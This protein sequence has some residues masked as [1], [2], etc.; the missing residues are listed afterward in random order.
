MDFAREKASVVQRAL[1]GALKKGHHEINDYDEDDEGVAGGRGGGGGNGGQDDNGVRDHDISTGTVEYK[2]Y[3]RRFIGLGALILLNIVGSW[4]WLTFAALSDTT[5]QYFRTSEAEVNWMSTAF[6]FSFA[7]ATPGVIWCMERFGPKP[8]IVTSAVLLI[9]GNWVRYAGT[10]TRIF[11]VAMFGQIVIGI[12]QPFFLSIPTKYSDMWFS[13]KGRTSATAIVSLSNPLGGALGS[14]IDP[15]LAGEPHQVP[16]MVLY[17]SII[18][19]A[20]AAPCFFIPARPP[21]PPNAVVAGEKAPYWSSLKRL[22]KSPEFLVIWLAFSIYVGLFNA[23]SSLLN[24]ILSPHGFTEDEAGITGALLIFVGL[25]AAAIISP[26][27]DYYKHY[28]TTVKILVPLIAATYVGLIWAPQTKTVVGPYVVCA[29]CGAFSFAALPVILE[30]L[31]E[32]TYPQPPELPSILCWTGGQI[33]G[34]ICIIVETALKKPVT[35]DPPGDMWDA[36]VFQACIA[37]AIV[38]GPLALGLFGRKHTLQMRRTEAEN[39]R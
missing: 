28:L 12:S 3:K 10:Q 21:T 34:A 20:A 23:C 6:L 32:I 29:L 13:D 31:V 19:S 14:L 1:D 22:A 18:S 35:A 38:P 7:F 5:A 2:L 26:F 37:C 11:G 39:E 9:L 33:L 16:R 27:T 24:Q 36:L 17:V 30:Y 15:M 8:S 25:G 4:D